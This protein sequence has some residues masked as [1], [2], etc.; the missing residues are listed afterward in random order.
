MAAFA[1]GIRSIPVHAQIRF[2]HRPPDCNLAR[3]AFDNPFG[4][5]RGYSDRRGWYMPRYAWHVFYPTLTGATGE[6]AHRLTKLPRWS[7]YLAAGA[8][9]GFGPHIRSTLRE[10]P[11]QRT[12]NPR[13]WAFDGL[14]RSAPFILLVGWNDE[15]WRPKLLA[16]TAVVTTYAALACY[17]SP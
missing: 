17:A 3:R 6:V 4:D 9:I 14:N 5:T 7:T 11:G 13:D 10:R 1:L 12:I 2:V 16:T 15:G 8:L